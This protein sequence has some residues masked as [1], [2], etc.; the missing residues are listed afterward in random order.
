MGVHDPKL[1]AV[2]FRKELRHYATPYGGVLRKWC[3]TDHALDS[4][5]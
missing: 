2:A 3:V 5:F 1:W 4:P